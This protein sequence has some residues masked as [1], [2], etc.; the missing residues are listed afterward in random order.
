MDSLSICISA[1]ALITSVYAVFIQR[2]ELELQ[3]AELKMQC[4]ELAKSAAAQNETQKALNTQVEMQALSAYINSTIHLHSWNQS[5]NEIKF[6]IDNF[7]EIKKYRKILEG[8][9]ANI[10]T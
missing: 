10:K 5:R 2:R 9:L 8:Y 3:R 4:D 6:A 1:F 7:N